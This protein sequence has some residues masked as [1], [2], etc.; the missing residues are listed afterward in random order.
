MFPELLHDF[1]K[2]VLRDQPEDI[3]EYGAQYFKA[4]DEGIEFTYDKVGK[5]VPP[6]RDREP[7]LGN[8]NQ[9]AEGVLSQEEQEARAAFIAQTSETRTQEQANTQETVSAHEQPADQPAA[10]AEE[11]KVDPNAWQAFQ[12]GP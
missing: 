6:P 9:Q 1:A 12:C 7:A 8:I 3:H 10:A 4:L 11:A 2:E 5:S